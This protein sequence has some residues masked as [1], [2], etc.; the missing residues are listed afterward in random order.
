MPTPA[1]PIRT[2]FDPTKLPPSLL[3]GKFLAPNCQLPGMFLA[4]WKN[5]EL[6]GGIHVARRI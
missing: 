1:I 3:K 5:H 6:H 4:A 2:F